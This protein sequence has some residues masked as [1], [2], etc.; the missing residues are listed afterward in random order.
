MGSFT[1]D[2]DNLTDY[3]TTT[4]SGKGTGLLF[5]SFVCGEVRDCMDEYQDDHGKDTPL[6]HTH[7]NEQDAFV[8]IHLHFVPFLSL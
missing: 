1:E 4:R 5:F 2:R 3:G 8:S 7:T 6:A